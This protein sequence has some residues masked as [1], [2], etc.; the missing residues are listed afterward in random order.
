MTET[1][2]DLIDYYPSWLAYRRWYLRIPGVQFAVRRQGELVSAGAIGVSNIDTGEQ[3]TSNHLFR[4]AAHSKTLAAVLVLQLAERGALRL[5]DS[6]GEHVPGLADSPVGDR[7]LS[8]LLTHSGGVI[9]DSEDGDFWQSVKPFPGRDE[10]IAIARAASSATIARNEHFKYS[11]IGYGLLGLVI[12]AVTGD[13]YAQLVRDQI[14]TPL[15]LTDLGGEYEPER[16]ADYAAAHSGL[17]GARNRIVLEHVDTRALAA[18]TGCFA[19]ARDL[20]AYF[21]ALMP[22]EHRLLNADSQ[23][24]QRHWHWQIKQGERHYGHGM[25]LDRIADIDLFGHTGGYPGHIT[26]SFA[27]ANE[28]WV[29]SAFTNSI[30]GAASQ[31]GSGFF[32][33]RNLARKAE[34]ETSDD[35]AVRFTGRF[36]SLWGV[37]DVIRLDGRLFAV[38]PTAPEPADEAVALEVADD[39]SLRIVG[40]RGGNSY[41]ELMRYEFGPDGIVSVRGDS[42]M[43]LRPFELP[44]DD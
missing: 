5:G 15:G 6:L 17:S 41:R 2:A 11:N 42:G 35:S 18:A 3:L 24:V 38:D 19:T 39:S 28:G 9:R 26:A 32:H 20:T 4:I 8:E 23:R 34:H 36:A 12:E 27:D 40:G 13:S 30:D 33:L 10:L 29:V 37:Q 31:L 7:T 43:S 22:G 21:S 44:S 16:S 14:A 25:S 1:W